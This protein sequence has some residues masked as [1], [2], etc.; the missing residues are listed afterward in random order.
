MKLV[1]RWLVGAVF[2]AWLVL[3]VWF[4]IDKNPDTWPLTREIVEWL[5]YPITAALV[6]WFIKWAPKHFD[7]AY[8]K[9][10]KMKGFKFEPVKWMTIILGV[11]IA[12][13]SVQM[14]MDL[15]PDRVQAAILI[16]I[17]VLTAILGNRVRAKVTA[18]ADPKDNDGNQLVPRR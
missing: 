16:A 14:F 15:L 1:G 5:P 10:G 13:S 12:L 2:V 9:E 6:G 8:R 7:D 18:L 4:S 3:E 11:L 17:A